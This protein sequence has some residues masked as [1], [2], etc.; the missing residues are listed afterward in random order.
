MFL[1]EKM[2][3]TKNTLLTDQRSDYGDAP[4]LKRNWVGVALV[5][6]VAL[7][8]IDLLRPKQS[9]ARP[10]L[11]WISPIFFGSRARSVAS[12]TDVA[13]TRSVRNIQFVTRTDP[14]IERNAATLSA[15]AAVALSSRG[16]FTVESPKRQARAPPTTALCRFF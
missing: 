8:R 1:P 14:H 12:T 3:N 15:S 6:V 13:T 11:A 4:V 16:S 7:L 5:C 2:R 10:P 9:M